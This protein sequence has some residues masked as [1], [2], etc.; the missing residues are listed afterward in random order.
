MKFTKEEISLCKQVAERYRNKEWLENKYLNEKLF[1]KEIAKLLGVHEWTIRY[2]LKKHGIRQRDKSENM[3]LLYEK[4]PEH[5]LRQRTERCKKMRVGWKEWRKKNP[6]ANKGKN[7]V[8]WK[9]GRRITTQGYV[10]VYLPN[11]PHSGKDLA[12]P[13]H[14]L[15]A[16]K[17]LG[18]RLKRGELV[19]H[20][21]GNKADNRNENFVIC[22]SSFH[23][24]IE[25]RMV[26]LYQEEH[27]AHI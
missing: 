17:A 18:R 6:N 5:L 2:W 7:A 25:Q 3:R 21:N 1:A 13:E 16:E 11:H 27:F 14:R 15:M 19:H 22:S 4:N 10:L 24:W 12:Y 8:N 9:G 20:I 23:R 26:K